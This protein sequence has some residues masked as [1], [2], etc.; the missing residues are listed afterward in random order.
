MKVLVTGA[1]GFVGR[2]MVRA[3]Q[4]AI[5]AQGQ[6]IPSARQGTR[7]GELGEVVAF[8][9]T[10][11]VQVDRTIRDLQPTHIVHLA[12]LSTIA[13]A[14]QDETLAWRVHVHGTLA[15]AR[16]IL[17]HASRCVLIYA[18][19]G[20]VYG[21]IGHSGK[22]LDERSLLAPTN[23]QMVTKSAADLA[24]GALATDGLKCVRFRPFNHTGPAQREL[25]ALPSFAK[26]IA[27]I[28]KG[29][30]SPL[31]RVGNLDTE[32][33][34]LDVR[35]VVAGYLQAVLRS[36]ELEP[37]IILNLASGVPRRMR[38]VLARMFAISGVSATLEVDR[39]L[40]RA[41]EITRFV[42]DASQAK[43]LLGWSPQYTLDETLRDILDY[44]ERVVD[45]ELAST[46]I[47]STKT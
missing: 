25:F 20:Q 26:Q 6:I 8:D 19:S 5:G 31:I 2:H 18:G 1:L 28:R 41:G 9:I 43:R 13:A 27:M 7:S 21:L 17:R 11:A 23:I 47:G 16:A 34:F 40:I 45:Q 12:G 14:S 39:R 4:Q 30:Q 42:G 10:D 44:W 35:D 32:R 46:R 29:V 36:Q 37:G 38:D 22:P 3:L 24:L 33:D 15:I